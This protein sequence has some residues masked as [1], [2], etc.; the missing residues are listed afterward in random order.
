M[1]VSELI[2]WSRHRTA[3]SSPANRDPFL[4]LQREVNRLFDN[5]WGGFDVAFASG[6]GAMGDSS[7]PHV[8][9]VEHDKEFILTV[10]M[11]GL[12]EK[13]FDVQ[14]ADQCVILRGDRQATHD[15]KKDGL[16]HIE[17][18]YGHFERRI[19][20]GVDIETDKARAQ[21]R[22]G[23]LTVTLPKAEQSQSTHRIP[24]TAGT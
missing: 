11:P 22:K 6:N 2:P 8:D 12:N 20:L 17:R 13:D 18:Y 10:E 21:L 7:W 3:A 24:I 5:T 16:R 15:E 4:S 9:L 1:S 23:V 19:P 14:F